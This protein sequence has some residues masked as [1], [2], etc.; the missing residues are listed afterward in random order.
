M[1]HLV[2]LGVA[3]VLLFL[4]LWLGAW[5]NRLV[6]QPHREQNDFTVGRKQDLCGFQVDVR[7]EASGYDFDEWQGSR[8]E[9]LSELDRCL[10]SCLADAGTV[11][12]GARCF[13]D[14]VAR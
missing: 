5:I 11:A 10:L 7:H 6:T 13:D 9:R 8:C 3:A 14:C 4:A 2:A 1:R 12:I